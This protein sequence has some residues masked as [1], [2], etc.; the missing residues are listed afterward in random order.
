MMT[1][2]ELRVTRQRITF[3]TRHPTSARPANRPATRAGDPLSAVRSQ[4]FR[5]SAQGRDAGRMTATHRLAAI[6]AADISSY[7]LLIGAVPN[8]LICVKQ[9]TLRRQCARVYPPVVALALPSG[10]QSRADPCNMA[11]RCV[12]SLPIGRNGAVRNAYSQ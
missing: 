12:I 5:W 9:V 11:C 8:I 1:A 3:L 6:L 4:L 10:R 2:P 7:S